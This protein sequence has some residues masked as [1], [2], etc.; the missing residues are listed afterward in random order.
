LISIIVT[1]D[2]EENPMN[3]S[4]AFLLSAL[5]SAAALSVSAH[6]SINRST[7]D[8]ARDDARIAADVQSSIDAN[9]SLGSTYRIQ[10][11]S[12]NQVVYL[13]GLVDSFREKYQV[14]TIA[15]QTP[16]VERVSN[17]IELQND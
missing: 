16:G 6:A 9:P 17:S 3:V 11:Q 5:A 4:N 2:E 14:Q 1:I 8:F 12:I 7:P 15:A 10:V 13:H